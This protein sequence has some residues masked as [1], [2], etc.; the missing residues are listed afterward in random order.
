MNHLI[1]Y[2]NEMAPVEACKLIVNAG[3]SI[4]MAGQLT[5]TSS[6]YN[7]QYID[8]SGICYTLKQ[9]QAFAQKA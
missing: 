2:A 6:E 4:Q 1:V 7:S 3:L 9:I 5:Q 8:Y